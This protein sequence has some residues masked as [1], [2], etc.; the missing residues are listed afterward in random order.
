MN[1]QTPGEICVPVVKPTAVAGV[2]V[3]RKTR[4]S[5][6]SVSTSAPPSPAS[7]TLVSSSVTKEPAPTVAVGASAT[8]V[9]MMACEALR[10]AVE[11]SL[12]VAVA[13]IPMVKSAASCSLGVT[14]K[15][16]SSALISAGEPVIS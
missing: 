2:P 13:T 10:V 6:P 11:P 16:S 15:L 4:T 8:G 12:S 5:E 14:A 7:A 3:T 9:T 1:S